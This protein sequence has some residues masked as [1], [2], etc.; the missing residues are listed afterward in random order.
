MPQPCVA[1]LGGTGQQGRGLAQRLAL[2]GFRIVI[3][4]RDP[5]RAAAMA[6]DWPPNARPATTADYRNAIAAADIVIL[7]LPFESVDAVLGEHEP[8]F[9]SD[10]IVVDI[11]VPL[12]F[13]RDALALAE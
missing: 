10:C 11:T 6:A 5:H 12:R 1:V 9:K 13:G 2:A 7:A 4:S 8:Q 3:G